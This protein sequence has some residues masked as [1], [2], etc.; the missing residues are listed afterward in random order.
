MK[1]TRRTYNGEDY[2]RIRKFL[3][4]VF[5]LN[6]KRQQSWDVVRFDYWRWHGIENIEPLQWKKWSFSGKPMTARSRLFLNPEG[7][8]DAFLQVHPGFRS[9]ALEEEML[10]AAEEHLFQT[11]PEGRRK[12]SVWSNDLD[13]LRCSL[14][15]KRGYA[16]GEWPEY[17]RRRSMDLPILDAQPAPGY[18]LRALA[19]GA[20][21]LDRCYASGLVFHPNDLQYAIDNR[22]DI[23]WYRNIQNAPLYRRDL[24]L[25]AAASD[26]S[27]AAF[28]T[29]WFDDVN[30]AG[31][32]EPVGTVPAHQRR[33]L[34]KALLCEGLRR[35]KKLGATMAYVGS[36]SPE[37]GALYASV[38]FT[39]Y[40][41]SIPWVKEY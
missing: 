24:D 23:S 7:R 3:R 18:T 17:Q 12:L 2:W 30:R 29:V 38:G 32:F 28:C 34:G 37:A 21:L 15:V 31:V 8:G 41:L 1:L 22:N 11:T 39:E 19:D 9:S 40:D 5:L 10:T 16:Q 25:L 20:E 4:D 13:D 33:G 36:Y 35:L 26:G 14:L 27:V 6:G